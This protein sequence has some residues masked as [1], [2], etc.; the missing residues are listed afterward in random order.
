MPYIQNLIDQIRCKPLKL[1][2]KM[3]YSL[4]KNLNKNFY[5]YTSL[6]ILKQNSLFSHNR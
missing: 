5:L 6:Q 1:F 2:Y 3:N 4:K